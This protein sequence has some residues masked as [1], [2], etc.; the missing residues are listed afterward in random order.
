MIEKSI[1]VKFDDKESSNEK[2]ELVE[3][4]ADL[5]IIKKSS[6][7]VPTYSIKA[8]YDGI[9]DMKL[10]D[11]KVPPKEQQNQK[12]ISTLEQR[13][14]LDPLLVKKKDRVLKRVREST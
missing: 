2:A 14:T 8:P 1:H 13:Q 3:V 7:C 9:E 12:P 6:T 5:E 11:D 4:F 10:N